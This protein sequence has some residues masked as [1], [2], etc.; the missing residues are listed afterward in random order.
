MRYV[1][2]PNSIS[3][4]QSTPCFSQSFMSFA[5][6]KHEIEHIVGGAVQAHTLT[7][8]FGLQR[9]DR[10]ELIDEVQPGLDVTFCLLWA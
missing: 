2:S 1:N 9:F 3:L 10:L 4:T 7:E 6:R 8:D 5:T